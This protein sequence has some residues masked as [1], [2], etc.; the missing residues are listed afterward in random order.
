MLFRKDIEPCCAH[1]QHSLKI[2]D[3]QALCKRHGVVL[4]NFKCR[5][6]RYDAT[7]RI[8][9]ESEYLPKDAFCED[10]FKF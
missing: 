4:H 7:K 2:N 9:P 10:D 1:C 3:E 8:P 6:Y 5:K